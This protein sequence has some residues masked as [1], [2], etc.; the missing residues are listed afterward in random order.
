MQCPNCKHLNV[1]RIVRHID[2]W[3]FEAVELPI[4]NDD[5]TLFITHKLARNH[6]CR[7][8]LNVLYRESHF[9]HWYLSFKKNKNC[10]CSSL[11]RLIHGWWAL[12]QCWLHEIRMDKY[13]NSLEYSMEY[14][15]WNQITCTNTLYCYH[16]HTNTP[17]AP[18]THRIL[19]SLQEHTYQFSASIEMKM[20]SQNAITVLCNQWWINPM[21][22]IICFILWAEIVCNNVRLGQCQ[23]CIFFLYAKRP[24]ISTL[25]AHLNIV[26]HPMM[27]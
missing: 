21:V 22:H 6:A 4:A 5:C 12:I 27:R 20:K 14:R 26:L 19:Q 9:V 16:T 11:Q 24:Y 7:I 18:P 17:T 13:G 10:H 15:M 8:E 3:F 1:H 25:Y 23:W 2:R